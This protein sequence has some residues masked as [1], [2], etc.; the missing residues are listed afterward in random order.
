MYPNAL[1]KSLRIGII[2]EFISVSLRRG[3]APN[4][5]AYYVFR[6]GIGIIFCHPK[7]LFIV[8][9][10]RNGI[11]IQLANTKHIRQ[12]RL[13]DQRTY[14][15]MNDNNI[16]VCT[17][18][19]EFPDAVPDRFL[20]RFPAGNH[21]SKFC[22]IELCRISFYNSM[23][24]FYTD[25]AY[26]VHLGMT[27]KVFH[28]VDQHGFVMDIQKLLWN[29][30]IHSRANS[31]G[32]NNGNCFHCIL[33]VKL[34]DLQYFQGNQSFCFR[35]PPIYFPFLEPK[36]FPLWYAKRQKPLFDLFHLVWIL[37]GYDQKII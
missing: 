15:I 4:R 3:Y 30:L 21:P 24:A 22:H 5:L 11:S 33:L 1:C 18:I 37:N 31:A 13:I 35:K 25:H 36:D 9:E 23:P 19:L 16:I 28:R 20:Y 34:T 17:I 32:D 7:N 6:T 12:Y 26:H 27:L 29:I 14:T 10:S 2:Q 8:G